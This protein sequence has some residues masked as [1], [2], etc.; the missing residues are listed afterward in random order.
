M[1]AYLKAALSPDHPAVLSKDEL[2]QFTWAYSR[3]L[4]Q[5]RSQLH[6]ADSRE[7]LKAK[8]EMLMDA[9]GETMNRL[10]ESERDSPVSHFST[11]PVTARPVLL[12]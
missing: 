10:E 11:S 7:K 2:A 9:L 3:Y 12:V 8:A 6:A 1:G 5:R 4:D